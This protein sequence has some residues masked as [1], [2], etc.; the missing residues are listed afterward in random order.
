MMLNKKISQFLFVLFLI[1]IIFFSGNAAGGGSPTD[2]KTLSPTNVTS[3]SATLSGSANPNEMDTIVLFSSADPSSS[4]SYFQQT[5]VHQIGNGSSSVSYSYTLIGLTPGTTYSYFIVASN[6]MGEVD[7]LVNTFTTPAQPSEPRNLSA[8]PSDSSVTLNWKVPSNYGGS[9]FTDADISYKIYR[10]TTS[11]GQAPPSLATVNMLTYTDTF[12][13]S[14][15]TYYYKVSAVNSA[16]EGT[17]SNETTAIVPTPKPSPTL[18]PVPPQLNVIITSTNTSVRIGETSTITITVI[19]DGKEISGASVMLGSKEGKVDPAAGTTDIYGKFPSTFTGTAAGKAVVRANAKKA[20]Y[21]EDTE[22]IQ[23]TVNSTPTPTATL[24]FKNITVKILEAGTGKPI[25]GAEIIIDGKPVA[26]TGPDGT[27]E[28]RLERGN[29]TNLSVVKVGFETITQPVNISDEEI[30][31]SV[32]RIPTP[33]PTPTPTLPIIIKPIIGVEEITILIL[34]LTIV[35]IGLFLWTRGKLH[36]EP[37]ITRVPGDGKSTLPI[38]VQFKNIFGKLR[39]QGKDREVVMETIAGTIQNV[40]IPAGK[41]FIE[42]TLTSSKECGSVIITA[43]YGKQKATAQVEFT[44]NEASLDVEISPATIKPDGKST[45][46]VNVKIRDADGNYIIS[47]NERTVEFTTTHGTITSSVR[48]PPKNPAAVGVITSSAKAE[49]ATVKASCY[50]KEGKPIVGEGKVVFGE[51]K[52]RHCEHCGFEM[53]M[54]PGPCP[55]PKCGKVPWGGGPG[56]KKCSNSH[57]EQ[58]IHEKSDYCIY[59]GVRQPEQSPVISKPEHT[60]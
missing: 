10:S 17:L 31:V 30:D 2:V 13:T 34:I 56:T 8:I 33:T 16:G 59:C 23:I 60:S 52:K 24:E 18:T 14:G 35:A 5:P 22:E 29:N 26:K 9:A 46:N 42:A 19:G 47:L 50:T 58:D 44:C 53:S 28:F 1:I 40:V 20:G 38:K 4:P 11:G 37:K 3:N 55:N 6:F 48:F 39:K 12:V 21:E 27:V 15:Q 51:D 45:A 57:C 54:D 32:P 43:R 36:L 7:G 49:T 25:G 41:E